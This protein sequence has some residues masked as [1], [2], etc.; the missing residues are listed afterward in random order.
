M[1]V[2]DACA[3][4]SW[5]TGRELDAVIVSAVDSEMA[6]VLTDAGAARVAKFGTAP[7]GIE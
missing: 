7:L 2:T 4:G 5:L 6:A 1:E 3:A